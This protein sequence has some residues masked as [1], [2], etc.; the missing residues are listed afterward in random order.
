MQAS[1]VVLVVPRR[2]G[3]VPA[4]TGDGAGVAAAGTDR[5]LSTQDQQKALS[6]ASG[7]SATE[8]VAQLPAANVHGRVGHALADTQ[9]VDPLVDG[10][11]SR[12]LG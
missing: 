3:M 8:C 12:A 10:P 1:G 6:V 4:A 9:R 2:P 7:E 5:R 11:R